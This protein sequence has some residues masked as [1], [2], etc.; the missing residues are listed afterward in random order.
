MY[1]EKLNDII[2]KYELDIDYPG[3]RKKILAEKYIKE[4]IHQWTNNLS[5]NQKILCI[6]TD[7][8]Q[9]LRMRFNTCD[10]IRFSYMIFENLKKENICT[11][12]QNI[13]VISNQ[14]S[15]QIADWLE[16]RG[17]Q[18]ELLYESFNKVGL[19]FSGEYYVFLEEP[20]LDDSLI[21]YKTSNSYFFEMRF[22]KKCIE[23]ED[24]NCKYLKRAIFISLVYK[25]FLLFEEYLSKLIDI[26]TLC[27][28][29]KY[30]A[31]K[32]EVKNLLKE[33]K[34]AISKKEKKDIVMLWMD[35]LGYENLQVMPYVSATM[36]K[37]VFFDN[38]F[39]LIP[40]TV[41]TYRCIFTDK[42][43]M[44]SSMHNHEKAI[45]EEECSICKYM[46]VKGYDFKVISEHFIRRGYVEKHLQWGGYMELYSPASLILWNTICC[47]GE[48]EKPVFLLAHELSHTHDPWQTTDGG[49]DIFQ[50]QPKRYLYARLELDRQ[51]EYYSDFM[52]KSIRIFMSDHGWGE[53]WTHTHAVLAI[54]SDKLKA[55]RIEQIFSYQNFSELLRQLLDDELDVSKLV[56]EYARIGCLPIYNETLVR[57]NFQRKRIPMYLIGYR[58]VVTQQYIY[59]NYQNG[60]EVLLNRSELP[61]KLYILPHK[62]DICDPKLLSYFRQRVGDLTLDMSDKKFVWARK[63]LLI[64]EKIRGIERNQLNYINKWLAESDLRRIVIRMGGEHSYTLYEWLTEDNQNRIVAFIDNDPQCICSVFGKQV[65]GMRDVQKMQIDG[66]ILS[67]YQYLDLL[68]SEKKLY[69]A[70]TVFFDIYEYIQREGFPLK[71]IQNDLVGLPDCEYEFCTE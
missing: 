51:I 53:P 70:G 69:P 28:K 36:K 23:N 30:L 18:Y 14:G 27:E 45:S 25:D 3:Y 24:D 22:L 7:E 61:R 49:E 19:L 46:S 52:E 64:A 37:G 54:V 6:A 10:D 47:M 40:W 67:S 11:R 12:Y 71:D 20:D 55:S 43:E 35:Q 63:S 38:A 56:T 48:N 68:R 1:D 29:E 50:D 16:S 8:E 62:S 44:S 2:F 42:K 26:L 33:I 9:I 13:Y 59:L 41:P 17:L 58:G 39:T 34:E 60:R 65:V 15:S 5:E 32:Q 66:V 21:G 57:N 4:W 31:L